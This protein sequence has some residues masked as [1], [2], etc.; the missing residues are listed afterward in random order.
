MRGADP[1]GEH[2][3]ARRDGRHRADHRVGLGIDPL[4]G[5]LRARSADGVLGDLPGDPLRAVVE[6]EQQRG[7][8]GEVLAVVG[9][10]DGEPVRLPVAQHARERRQVDAIRDEVERLHR[11]D[12][13]PQIWVDAAGEDPRKDRHHARG[14]PVDAHLPFAE[15]CSVAALEGTGEIGGH[16]SVPELVVRSLVLEDHVEE[17]PLDVG[18]QLEGGGERGR[19]A[20]QRHRAAGR[21]GRERQHHVG[22]HRRVGRVLRRQRIE[23]DLGRAPARWCTCC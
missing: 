20:E 14:L 23:G 2:E 11:R 5:D 17:R 21:A 22:C 16:A 3:C 19:R 7:G 8:G 1:A 18:G 12:R 6:E 10:V 9:D 15:R 4:R 13:T